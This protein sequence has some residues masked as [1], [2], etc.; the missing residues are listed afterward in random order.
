MQMM[1]KQ[2]KFSLSKILD[3]ILIK[4]CSKTAGS[5][6]KVLRFVYITTDHLPMRILREFVTLERAAKEKIQ[7][8]LVS[9]E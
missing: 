4:E 6:C 1:L 3:I 2:P 9:M 5:L 8:R 7:T